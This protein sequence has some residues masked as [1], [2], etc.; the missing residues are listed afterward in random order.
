[1]SHLSASHHVVW[2][3]GYDVLATGSV[4]LSPDP[5]L[6]VSSLGGSSTSLVISSLTDSDA[7]QYVC[8]VALLD[9]LLSVSHSLD[10]LSAPTVRP[11]VA[12]T[13]VKEGEDATLEC[14]VGGNPTPSVTWS[15]AGGP[16]PA[17]ARAACPSSN[18]LALA[19]V[20]R[21]Q[22]GTYSCVATNG[23]GEAAVAEIRIIV[24]FPPHIR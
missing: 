1:M 18:C 17:T 8:Q 20:A 12:L 13:T 19:G 6:S 22:A 3:R 11:V 10:V 2:R 5:R 24:Q 16:L 21:T 14:E 4:K 15:R 23:V 9:G 7:G